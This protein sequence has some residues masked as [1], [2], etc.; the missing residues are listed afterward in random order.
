MKF[1]SKGSALATVLM[2]ST[3]VVGCQNSYQSQ[4]FVDEQ[5]G[6]VMMESLPVGEASAHDVALNTS[7]CAGGGYGVKVS[8]T[9]G[10]K[11]YLYDESI[12]PCEQSEVLFNGRSKEGQRA[13]DPTRVN[14]G[15]LDSIEPQAGPVK[16]EIPSPMLVEVDSATTEKNTESKGA[17][18]ER[19]INQWKSDSEHADLVK[20]AEQLLAHVRDLDRMDRNEVLK[21][22][23][24]YI[25][26]L[27]QRVRELEKQNEQ[28]KDNGNRLV[29]DLNQTYSI[30]EADKKDQQYRLQELQNQLAAMEQKAAEYENITQQMRSKYGEDVMAYRARIEDLTKQLRQ[31]EVQADQSRQNMVLEAAKKIAEAECLAQEAQLAKRLT[32]QRRAQRLQLEASDMLD[33]ARSLGQG[34][35]IVLPAVSG[36]EKLPEFTIDETEN[37]TV[38]PATPELVQADVQ[39]VLMNVEEGAAKSTVSLEGM[40]VKLNEAGTPLTEVF[41]RLFDDL[42]DR[43]GLWQV[44]WQ[45]KPENEYLRHQKWHVIAEAPLKD[46]LAYVSEKMK[47]D[48]NVQLSFQRFDQSRLFVISDQ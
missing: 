9:T 44:V 7:D 11:N 6:V 30:A 10:T 39:P 21:E 3:F 26:K 1:L 41:E 22:H 16:A 20:D 34:Q 31:A 4:H 36:L 29:L 45:L 43:A 46:F 15:F 48:K 27:Q 12:D 42:A 17:G 19:T 32:M 28:L 18:F 37:L 14:I 8:G 2:T 13:A 5:G 40:E 25:V 24:N 47:A 33:Q 38:E 35:P 23:Q